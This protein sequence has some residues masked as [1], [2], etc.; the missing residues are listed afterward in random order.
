MPILEIELHM[1]VGE[2][3][4]KFFEHLESIRCISRA[5]VMLILQYVQEFSGMMSTLFVTYKFYVFSDK[6]AMLKYRI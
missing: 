3:N 6:R 4:I 2:V 1:R 5:Y